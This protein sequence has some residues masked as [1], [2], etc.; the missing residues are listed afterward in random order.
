MHMNKLRA[1]ASP[2]WLLLAM[3]VA[4]L[5]NVGFAQQTTADVLGT[6]TDNTG[7]VVAGASVTVESTATNEKR[8]ATTASNGDFVVNLLKPSNYTV[9]ITA[10]GFKA[11]VSPNLQL[12]AGDR[13]RVNAHLE[14]GQATETVTVESVA[15]ALQTDSSVMSTTIVQKSVED[16][17]LNGRNFVQ[18][19]QLQPGANDGLQGGGLSSGNQLDDRRQTA[20]L[21]VNGQSDVLNNQM[22]DGADN[23]ERLIGTIG[24]RPAIDAIGEVRVQTNT[25]TAE[26]GRTGGGIINLLTKSGTNEIHGTVFEFFRNDVLNTYPYAFGVTLPKAELRQNQFGG[27]IGGPIKKNKTFF[28]GDYEGFRLVQ[29]QSPTTSVV[30]TAYQQDNPG[31]FTDVGGSL[32]PASNLDK[33]GLAYFS[34][35]PKP[36]SGTNKYV[37]SE[38][39][40]QFSHVFDVRAD[41]QLNESNSLFARFSYNKVN[42]ESPG[43]F[44]KKEFG[45]TGIELYPSTG[46]GVAPQV[47]YNAMLNYVHTFTPNLLLE[48][49]AAYTRVDNKSMPENMGTNPHAALGQVNVNTPIG[50]STGLAFTSIVGSTTIGSVGFAPVIDQDNTF[51]YAGSLTWTRG[52]HNVKFGSA[53]IRRQLTSYQSTGGEGVWI[54]LSLQNLVQGNVFYVSRGLSLYSPH[55]R[56]WE[57]SVYV[58]DDWH[59]LKNLTLNLGLRYDMYTPFTEVQNRISTFN[60]TTG[61]MM[62]AGQNGVS[63]IAGIKTDYSNLAP[64]FGFAYTARPGTVIRGGFGLGF[65]PM[66]ATST[67]TLKNDPFVSN[68]QCTFCAAKFATGLPTITASNIDDANSSISAAVDPN[69]RSSYV[70][71]YNLTTQQEFSG[72]VLT[73]SYVG[74]IGRRLATS[75]DINQP[76]EANALSDVKPLRPY[77]NQHPNLGNITTM[78]TIGSSIYSSFQS[79]FERRFKN[80][81]VV[82]ANYTL[83]HQLD[84]ALN[85]GGSG[86]GYGVFQSQIKKFDWGN[87][88]ID[89]RHRIALTANYELPFGKR[90]QGLTKKL[91]NGWQVNSINVWSTGLPFSVVNS[92]DVAGTLNGGSDRPNQVLAHPMKSNPGIKQFFNVQAFQQQTTGT[93]GATRGSAVGTVG[94]FAERRNQLYG[95]HYRHF[96][97]SL[98]KVIPLTKRYNLEFRAESFNIT[99]TTNFSAPDASLGDANLDSNGIPQ[100]DENYTFGQITST[101][102]TIPPRQ[103][104]FAL[105]LHY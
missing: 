40:T 73:L 67:S 35:F 89:I 94:T 97:L 104:Q 57:P 37:G 25:Y 45:S 46:L 24:V 81:L 21:S 20:S 30:P 19:V 34:L 56:V 105:K 9:T 75:L 47:A 103:I 99:N 78:K 23:N 90:S 63:S 10:P 7:A 62:V 41:H 95:P 66:N 87:G 85:L 2:L 92:T 64:R 83:G 88:A 96:D 43:V 77:Y 61:N 60:P 27:S 28:F 91:I 13:A 52:Q 70:Y 26:A 101:N 11:F 54:F 32:I 71:Q 33:A 38:K 69:F 12:A 18:L 8:E 58:Q 17:P 55:L 84:D 15:P 53:L 6:V 48:L 14:I 72:N 93:Y 68:Y 1:K 29:G 76:T 22:L 49:K 50:G 44:P 102:S 5:P 16:L 86:G 65:V 4:F 31:D 98:F 39:K 59:A 51:Q 36:N 100:V 3:L 80:G 82:N 79:A 74:I 42:T